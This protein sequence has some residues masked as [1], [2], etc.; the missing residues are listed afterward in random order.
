MVP[1]AKKL[2]AG[3]WPDQARQAASSAMPCRRSS[4]SCVEAAKKETMSYAEA[5]RV[6][7]ARL[8]KLEAGVSHTVLAL[9]ALVIFA[10]GF[11]LG[12]RM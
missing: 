9:G 10:A 4:C 7:Q 1:D 2:P 12:R 6:A 5:Q 11:G 8:A 3:P